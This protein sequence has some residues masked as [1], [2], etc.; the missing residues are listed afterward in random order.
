[1]TRWTITLL[2]MT[3]ILL[4]HLSSGQIDSLYS[5]ALKKADSAYEFKRW[6]DKDNPA[7]E[8]KFEEAKTLYGKA[9]QINPS[10]N[11]PGNRI[12]EI[13]KTLYDF[14]T[15]PIYNKLI[16]KADSLYFANNFVIAKNYYTKADSLYADEYTKEKLLF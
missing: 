5:I 12:K 16:S 3:F 4:G 1:M 2:T 11:Y 10:D 15:K 14:K 8:A 7:D 6:G 13:E 9:L